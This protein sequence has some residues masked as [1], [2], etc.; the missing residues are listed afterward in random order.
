MFYFNLVDSRCW[1]TLS[2]IFF[3]QG[4]QVVIMLVSWPWNGGGSLKRQTSFS[5][6]HSLPNLLVTTLTMFWM[7]PIG[8][9]LVANCNYFRRFEFHLPY[10]TPFWVIRLPIRRVTIGVPSGQ[11]PAAG[12]SSTH[13]LV[14]H[15][16]SGTV[17]TWDL[18][19]IFF[20]PK[21]EIQTSLHPDNFWPTCG[22]GAMVFVSIAHLKRWSSNL[23]LG[24]DS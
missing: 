4:H 15:C 2:V 21:I 8:T 19:M 3:D 13:R 17:S 24:F 9:I 12:A 16:I 6:R 5:Y 23:F 18:S 14:Y 7:M 1:G 11:W 22:S 20:H 10:R